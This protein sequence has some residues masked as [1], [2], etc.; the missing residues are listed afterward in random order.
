[1]API[2]LPVAEVDPKAL[3]HRDSQFGKRL[4]FRAT[5]DN[6][7]V[8]LFGAPHSVPSIH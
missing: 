1:M 6:R 8:G 7:R 4:A 5:H 2:K 3:G